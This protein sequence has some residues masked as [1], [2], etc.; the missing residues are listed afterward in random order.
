MQQLQMTTTFVLIQIEFFVQDFSRWLLV[1]NYC[2]SRTIV[3]ICSFQMAF[4]H[5][6]LKSLYA[7]LQPQQLSP[8]HIVG[9]D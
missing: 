7:Q 4:R 1:T 6:P 3:V 9:A 8:K 5:R 2:S